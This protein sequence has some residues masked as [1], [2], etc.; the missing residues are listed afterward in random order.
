MKVVAHNLD[1]GTVEHAIQAAQVSYRETNDNGKPSKN[2]IYLTDVPEADCNEYLGECIIWP[3]ASHVTIRTVVGLQTRS[4]GYQ[5]GV[6]SS[7]CVGMQ[8]CPGW[9]NVVGRAGP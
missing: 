8:M 9:L 3:W 5:Q 7:Y 1:P 2:R 4:D 6:I